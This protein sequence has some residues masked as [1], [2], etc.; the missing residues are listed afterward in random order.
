MPDVIT[1]DEVARY[2]SEEATRRNGKIVPR[3]PKGLE[4]LCVKPH[5][6]VFNV[7]PWDWERQLGGL[8]TKF[9]AKCPEGEPYGPVP[10][11]FGLY[12]NETVA[13]DMNK[14]ENRQEDGIEI[15]NAFLSRGRDCRP[16]NSLEQWGIGI[17]EQW[18][19]T[20][21]EIAAAQRRLSEK[22]DEL[23]RDGD[24]YYEQRKHEDITEFHR[25]A[26]RKKKLAKGWLNENPD[27]VGC[28]AC[29]QQVMP[30]IAKCPHCR[31]TL[32]VEL[33]KK[34]FP[35]EYRKTA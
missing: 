4:D 20:A 10:L 8:G 3:L 1:L 16:E 12:H 15:A 11:V 27:M 6:Y 29:G 25:W 31:A 13:V 26:A 24:R 28:P 2:V 7:G 35:E 32:N 18:P 21:S 33:A 23:I 30:N 19:P 5:W 22:C 9:L 17:S 14:M 34:Y